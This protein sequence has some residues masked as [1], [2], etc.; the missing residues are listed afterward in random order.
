M[1]GAFLVHQARRH[2]AHREEAVIV[3]T[4]SVAV[5][6][7][8][9]H[10]E[11]E[12]VVGSLGDMYAEARKAVFEVVGALLHIG[13]SRHHNGDV[14]VHIHELAVLTRHHILYPLDVLR[15]NAVARRRHRGVAVLLLFELCKFALLPRHVHHLVIHN[16]VGT[17]N[18]VEYRHQIDRHR[19]V[20]HLDVGE[21]SDYRRQTDA[22]HIDKAV[23]FA[24]LVA[25]RE[26]FAIGFQIVHRQSPVLEVQSIEAADVFISLLFAENMHFHTTVLQEVVHLAGF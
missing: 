18:A 15:G 12:L 9:V 10:I 23:R 6:R 5:A 22:I 17:W 1:Q 26:L 21:W 11:F 19:G 8:R 14:A 24:H 25:H 3:G 13:V 4:H 2:V 7:E 20:V 16:A